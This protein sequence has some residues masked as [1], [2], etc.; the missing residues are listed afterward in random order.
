[1]INVAVVAILTVRYFINRINR[2]IAS[3]SIA[4]LA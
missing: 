2:I 4:R 3:Y 1:M